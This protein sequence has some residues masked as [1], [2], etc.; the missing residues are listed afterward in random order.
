MR[1]EKFIYKCSDCGKEYNSSETTYLCPLCNKRNTL[2]SPP[3]GVLKTVYDYK[4]IQKNISGFNELK[5]R[6]F[7]DLLP[8]ENINTLPMLRVGKTPLYN[9]DKLDGKSLPFHI[10][11]KDDSQNPTYSFKDRASALVS[12]Y[13]KEK[14][15][16]TIVAASTGNAGSSLAGICAAQGQK[17]II[18]IPETAPVA[19]LTQIIMY[20]ATI[21]PIKGTYDEAFDFSIKAT[22]EFGWYNRNTAFNPLTIEGKKTVSFELIEDLAFKVPDKIFVPVGDGVIISA[23]YKGFEDLYLPNFIDR[24]PVIIAVQ[25]KGSDNLVRNI[26]NKDF[27]IISSSTIADSISVDIPR[28]FYMTQQF[29]QRY[30]GE[31]IT[32]SDEEIIEASA[33]LS[34]NTGLFAEPA[35]AAAFAG[36]LSYRNNGRLDDNS[37]NVVLLTGSGLKDLKSVTRILKIPASIYPTIDNLKNLMA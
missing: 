34:R 33:I 24:M 36:L 3:E 12:A 23:V 37:D 9:L 7:I 15:F 16:D 27:Q 1:P 18:M 11:L 30:N 25:S 4:K 29:I 26:N 10:R 22:L 20:G 17:A 2:I 8:I 32:V 14:N 13:A 35:A 19:K 5:I 6:N 21:I 28:N 31:S